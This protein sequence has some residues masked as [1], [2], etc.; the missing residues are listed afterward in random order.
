MGLNILMRKTINKRE[1]QIQTMKLDE[2]KENDVNYLI[3]WY[4]HRIDV[5]KNKTNSV[6]II[7]HYKRSLKKLKQYKDK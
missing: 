1:K 6:K 2:T 7:N 5:W 4:N 3:W